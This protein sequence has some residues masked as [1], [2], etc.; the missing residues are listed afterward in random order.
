MSQCAACSGHSTLFLCPQCTSELKS[1]LTGLAQGQQHRNGT[2]SPGW[3]ELLAD[4]ATG[5]T[6]MG[7]NGPRT[8]SDEQPMV[9]NLKASGLLNEVH[10][11]LSRWCRDISESRAVRWIP[12]QSVEPGFYGP[13]RR[14]WRRLPKGYVATSADMA[15]WLAVHVHA[16]A[17]SEDAGMCYYEVGQVIAKIEKAINRPVPPR[18]IGPCPT[19][20]DD[21]RREC[22]VRLTARREAVEVRCPSCKVTHSVQELNLRLINQ[23]AYM[24]YKLADIYRILSEAGEDVPKRSTFYDWCSSARKDGRLKIRGYERPNGRTVIN[25]HSEA[26][27]ELF[28]VADVRIAINERRA[29]KAGMA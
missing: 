15:T 11:V 25:R 21:H 27:Q 2:N 26:D 13:L 8:S 19:I 28:W 12:V 10:T 24:K 16:I 23:T 18:F 14:G 7:D 1:N 20:V 9:V 17:C 29:A 4:A 3:L 6:R 22:G 5:Q